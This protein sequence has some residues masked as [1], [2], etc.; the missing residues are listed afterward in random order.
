MD[1]A[2]DVRTILAARLDHKRIEI[3]RA[4]AADSIVRASVLGRYLLAV[5][6]NQHLGVFA[7]LFQ[8]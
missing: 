1:G 3:A 8:I 2:V 6:D 5:I 7:F 4:V